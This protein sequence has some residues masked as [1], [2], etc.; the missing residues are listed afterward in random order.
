MAKYVYT[1]LAIPTMTNEQSDRSLLV[2]KN[3]FRAT[4]C[5]NRAGHASIANFWRLLKA[6]DLPSMSSMRQFGW[7]TRPVSANSIT[8]RS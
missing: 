5:Q 8:Q 6:Q 2:L 4:K 3:P 1:E 7:S